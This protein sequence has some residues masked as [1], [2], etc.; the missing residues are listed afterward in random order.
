MPVSTFIIPKRH[1]AHVLENTFFHAFLFI[2]PLQYSLSRVPLTR[3]CLS[4][5]SPTE[6]PANPYQSGKLVKK[7]Q[8]SEV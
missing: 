3:T 8:D 7:A 1:L 6:L 2:Y 4:P 5:C